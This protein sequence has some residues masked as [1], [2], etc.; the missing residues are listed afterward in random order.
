MSDLPVEQVLPFERGAMESF[1]IERARSRPTP[2]SFRPATAACCFY[3]W[4]RLLVFVF[5]TAN[6]AMCVVEGCCAQTQ[7]AVRRF[8]VVSTCDDALEKRRD[9]EPL[10]CAKAV[11]REWHVHS[12]YYARTA[13]DV[14]VLPIWGHTYCWRLERASSGGWSEERWLYEAIVRV[15]NRAYMVPQGMEFDWRELVSMSRGVQGMMTAVMGESGT[16][17]GR[18]RI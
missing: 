9:D 10:P 17:S 14:P 15:D 16:R 13:R 4:P 18:T 7:T 12:A 11:I 5:S 3:V 6:H 8:A 2:Q 1:T